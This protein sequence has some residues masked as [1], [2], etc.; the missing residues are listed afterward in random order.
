MPLGKRWRNSLQRGRDMAFRCG[1]VAIVGQPN[2]GKSTLLNQIVGEQLAI[3]TDKPQTTRHRIL[4]ILNRPRAQ[5]LFLDTPGFH[6]S[7]KALNRAM[8]DTVHEAVEGADLFCL[9]VEPKTI[10]DRLNI[11]LSQR[12]DSLRT[13]VVIN[14]CDLIEKEKFAGLANEIHDAWGIKEATIVS[15]LHGLGVEGLI[16]ILIEKLPRGEAR[17][18][19]DEMTEHSLRFLAAELIREELYLQMHQE[20]PYASTVVIDEFRE[21]TALNHVTKILATI[22]LDKESQKPMV[23]GQGGKRIKEIGTKARIKIE[24]LVGTKVFLELFV[25]VETDW[26]KD[27]QRVATLLQ[28]ER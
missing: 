20:I 27:A 9:V 8:L 14:K 28:G 23:I 10:H 24:Q 16:D 5:V 17:Y 22:V 15:A 3:V 4:G 1:S 11:E 25:R 18:A 6:H 2:V 13:I 12:L 21:A 7:K 26:T 19:A